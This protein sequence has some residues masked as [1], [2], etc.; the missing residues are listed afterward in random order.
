MTTPEAGKRQ[1]DNFISKA[2]NRGKEYVNKTRMEIRAWNVADGF[3]AIIPYDQLHLWTTPHLIKRTIPREQ[4]A[5]KY[6]ELG[7]AEVV[8]NTFL[9]LDNPRDFSE[10]RLIFEI[11]SSASN[12]Q[13]LALADSLLSFID[14]E[15]EK[16]HKKVKALAV[17]FYLRRN[18]Q[19]HLEK[20][21]TA[22]LSKYINDPY[23][24]GQVSEEMILAINAELES[25]KTASSEE[26]PATKEK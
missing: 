17:D 14:T 23:F 19:V 24:V 20:I 21:P 8:G 11:L 10:N 6:E 3:H 25:R 26:D 4:I 22:E 9:V 18:L 2:I 16:F 13:L 5:K 7:I 1:P 12:D 15:N